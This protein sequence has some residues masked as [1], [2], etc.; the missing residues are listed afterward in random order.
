EDSSMQAGNQRGSA[1][2]MAI[3]LLGTLLVLTLT[4]FVMLETN[5]K[6]V[7]RQLAFYGQA[8][9]A[10]QAGLIETL[11]WFRRQT[12]QPVA[13][14]NPQLNLAATTPVNDTDDS[15]IGIVR[16]YELSHTNNTWAR[17]EVRKSEVVNITALRGKSGVGTVWQIVSHGYVYVRNDPTKPYNQAPNRVIGQQSASTEL[18]RLQMQLPGT[19]AVMSGGRTKM[20]SNAR[21]YAVKSGETGIL[22]AP[23]ATNAPQICAFPCSLVGS[24]QTGSVNPFNVSI[25]TVFGVLEPELRGMADVVGATQA[26]L[27][28]RLPDMSLTVVTG[29]ATFDATHPLSGSGILVVEGN[30]TLGAASASAFS[31]LIWV[32][33]NYV[34]NAPSQVSGAI[35]TVGTATFQGSGDFSEVS[36]D[37][38]MLSTIRQQMGQYRFSRAITFGSQ[39]R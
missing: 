23:P 1:A 22:Y 15:T 24:P 36:Y 4:S 9:N 13:A 16:D 30:L 17:Y 32:G 21:I 35:A 25:S 33:G 34:Q 28:S 39:W 18:Q 26:D 27:P 2:M 7:G 37:G 8:S 3:F 19:A 29:N 5:N 38:Q 14:F 11:S 10:A 12:A 6:V 31:G 20:V